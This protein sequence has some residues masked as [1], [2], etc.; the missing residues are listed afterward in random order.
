MLEAGV[1]CEQCGSTTVRI[2]S[3]Y[4]NLDSRGSVWYDDT[5]ACGWSKRDL[6]VPERPRAETFAEAFERLN[7]GQ[8]IPRPKVRTT[9][10]GLQTLDDIITSDA[11]RSQ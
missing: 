6:Y 8:K 7:P 5:C 9:G 10:N 1:K 4:T 2:Y 3:P 11:E